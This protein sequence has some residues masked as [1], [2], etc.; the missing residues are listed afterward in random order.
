MGIVNISLDSEK[1]EMNENNA[2]ESLEKISKVLAPGVPVFIENFRI[3]D[4]RGFP[5]SIVNGKMFFS[6]G[7]LTKDHDFGIDF[8][9]NYFFISFSESPENYN[10]VR[11]EKKFVDGVSL[12]HVGFG[13]VIPGSG[14]RIHGGGTKRI[15]VGEEIGKL[16]P[17]QL[18]ALNFA[19]EAIYV[20]VPIIYSLPGNVLGLRD[21]DKLKETITFVNNVASM[22]CIANLIEFTVKETKPNQSAWGLYAAKV[23]DLAYVGDM[24]L[25]DFK[26]NFFVEDSDYAITRGNKSAFNAIAVVKLGKGTMYGDMYIR[27][28]KLVEIIEN[29]VSSA[30]VEKYYPRR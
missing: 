7:V 3:H 8:L 21:D 26:K 20:N 25:G 29:A 13:E 6:N 10:I 16:Y 27:P 19:K 2:K 4:D 9:K 5:T 23:S 24:N 18:N 14:S 17:V 1:F 15:I 30:N 11:N 12:P 28:I 22:N